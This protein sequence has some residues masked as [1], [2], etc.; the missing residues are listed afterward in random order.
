MF[1]RKMKSVRHVFKENKRN[2]NLKRQGKGFISIEK[3][4]W[5]D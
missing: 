2:N 5:K 4:K 3:E 1:K